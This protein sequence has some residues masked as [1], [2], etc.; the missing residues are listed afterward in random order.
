MRPTLS[1]GSGSSRRRF[2]SDRRRSLVV[3]ATGVAFALV[4]GVVSLLPGRIDA[5]TSQ[6]APPAAG[7][8]ATSRTVD[9]GGI[10]II[11][12]QRDDPLT[13]A[14]VAVVPRSQIGRL[15]TVLASNQLVGGTGRD[16]PTSMCFRLH[17]HVAVN[18]DRH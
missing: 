11:Q 14:Q 1:S 3:T 7:W 4:S 10:E 8:R 5:A 16:L 17:C 2:D 9:R 12:L 6:P 13:R 18:G 15:R